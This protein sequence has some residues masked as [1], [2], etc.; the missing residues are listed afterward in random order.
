MRNTGKTVQVKM[1]K[2]VKQCKGED[3]DTGK[4]VKMRTQ[5]K[6]CKGKDA[7]TGKTV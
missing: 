1:R 2:Q 5:V 6:Q 3:E 4:T 7:D